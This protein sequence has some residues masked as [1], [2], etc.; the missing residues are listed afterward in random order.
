MEGGLDRAV[1]NDNDVV[2]LQGC[3]IEY[4]VV[5]MMIK[6]YYVVTEPNLAKA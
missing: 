6:S 4:Y 3:L 1:C 2:C 5:N